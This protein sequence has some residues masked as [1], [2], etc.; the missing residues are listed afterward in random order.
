MTTT[1]L[2]TTK[3]ASLKATKAD[4]KNINAKNMTL[5]GKSIPEIIDENMIKV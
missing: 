3:T 2:Y 4:I 1:N 5:G